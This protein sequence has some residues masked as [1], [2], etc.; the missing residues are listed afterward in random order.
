[1]RRGAFG[2]TLK[3]SIALPYCSAIFTVAVPY[4]RAENFAAITTDKLTG[5]GTVTDGTSAAFFSAFQ[6]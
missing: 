2:I 1:M 6:F 4:L 3:F 5:K